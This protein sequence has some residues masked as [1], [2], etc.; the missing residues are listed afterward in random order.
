MTARP[1]P[2]DGTTVRQRLVRDTRVRIALAV[3][4]IISVAGIFA[5]YLAP[6]D[7]REQLGITSLN[8]Q[9]PSFAHPLG[10]DA[11]S[12]DVLS[13]LIFGIRAKP[14]QAEARK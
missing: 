3:L 10:T 13:R 8:A 5:P 9:S 14:A 4:A 7:P 12:R 2:L 11:F 6:Y 1:M